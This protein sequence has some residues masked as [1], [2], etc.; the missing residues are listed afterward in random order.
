M[1]LQEKIQEDLVIAM[2]AKDELRV[3]TLRFLVADGKNLKIEKQ[4][5]L[6][7]EDF[8]TLVERQVKR[9]RESIEG[10][11]KGNRAEMVEKE[12]AELS[13]LQSYLPEQLGTAEI[14]RA[15]NDAI[16]QTGATSLNEMGK[17]MSQLQNLRGKAD[18][19]MVS[20]M[21]KDKLS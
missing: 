8:Q 17:V 15:V 6:T 16:S 19:T 3:S 2:K 18:F 10:F 13:I 7:D 20:Q 21:V 12:K 11:E 14:E 5:E 1:S 9:H 4:R